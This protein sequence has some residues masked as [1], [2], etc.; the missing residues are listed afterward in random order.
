MSVLY[1]EKLEKQV[2]TTKLWQ[3]HAD[4]ADNILL[5]VALLLLEK[6]RRQ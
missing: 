4:L 2:A 6:E 5:S 3:D 1:L